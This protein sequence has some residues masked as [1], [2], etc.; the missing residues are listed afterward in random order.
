[1]ARPIKETPILRGRTSIAFIKQ[2]EKNENKKK[3]F[4]LKP[5]DP[6]IK[7]KIA[8]ESPEW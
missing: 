5:I 2:L 1:M 7:R 4:S 8:D 3:S 6:E